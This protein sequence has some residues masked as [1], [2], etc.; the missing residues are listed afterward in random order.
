MKGFR[1]RTFY[2]SYDEPRLDNR[3]DLLRASYHSALKQR[4]RAGQ[5]VQSAFFLEDTSVRIDALSTTSE[6]PGVNIKFWMQ[7]MTF[8]RLNELIQ[9]AGGSRFVTVRSD[10]VVHVPKKFRRALGIETEF[11]WIHGITE[12]RIVEFDTAHSVNLAYPWL[13]EQSFNR[14]FIPSG[15]E[16]TLNSLPIELANT[17]DFRAKAFSSMLEKIGPL[18][19]KRAPTPRPPK[20]LLLPRVKPI[21]PIL[22]ICGYS[23]AGKTTLATALSQQ[24]GYLH[25][26]ASDFMQA[27][28][29]Q[30]YGPASAIPIG[31]FAEAALQDEPWIAAEP[32]ANFI[33]RTSGECQ[34]SCRINHAAFC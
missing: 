17:Y 24:L 14:W 31:E 5:S 23:C 16:V 29:W 18:I 9:L 32:I 15:A 30:R 7:G 11:L 4:Q 6:V 33:Q 26:E 8:G 3:E 27:A 2:A 1:E 20:Q 10:I 34:D 25:L 28:F 22:V 19:A 21:P 13:H 12:G